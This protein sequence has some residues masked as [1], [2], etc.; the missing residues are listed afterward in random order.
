M[1]IVSIEDGPEACASIA[2]KPL[3]N[4]THPEDAKKTDFLSKNPT[5]KGS[6]GPRPGGLPLRG[7]PNVGL[8]EYASFSTSSVVPILRISDLE[9][10]DQTARVGAHTT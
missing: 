2:R 7:L 5:G 1:S 8:F 4:C 3:L 9:H 10:H 6:S